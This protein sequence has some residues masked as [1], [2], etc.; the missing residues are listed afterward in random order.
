MIFFKLCNQLSMEKNICI[1]FPW[2]NKY[3][4]LGKH[5]DDKKH[6]NSKEWEG[7]REGS[8]NVDIHVQCG[9]HN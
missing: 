7:G 4:T 1:R 8:V 9:Y 6:R 2:H 3:L 5:C